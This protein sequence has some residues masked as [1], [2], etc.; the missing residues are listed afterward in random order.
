MNNENKTNQQARIIIMI[1]VLNDGSYDNTI[2]MNHHHRQSD[3]ERKLVS[4]SYLSDLLNVDDEKYTIVVVYPTFFFLIQIYYEYS[5]K[6]KE[7]N[8]LISK[9]F[10]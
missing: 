9:N 7:K 10:E 8:K 6:K 4:W 5:Q 2:R 1:N 3:V